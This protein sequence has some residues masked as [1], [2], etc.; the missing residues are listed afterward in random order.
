MI[1]IRTAKAETVKRTVG[2]S[3]AVPL[4]A[5]SLALIGVLNPSVDPAGAATKPVSKSSSVAAPKVGRVCKTPGQVA[6]TAPNQLVCQR[7]TNNKLLW[8]RSRL[9]TNTILSTP[10]MQPDSLQVNFRSSPSA[11]GAVA[12]LA[13]LNTQGAEG[14]AY[15]GPVFV[16]GAN[17]ETFLK[18][19]PTTTYRYET[20]DMPTSV[21]GVMS[22]LRA[23]GKAGLIYKGPVLFADA[24]EK[25]S[26]LFLRATPR[27]PRTATATAHGPQMNR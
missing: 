15:I 27:R 18:A 6:G 9:T 5:L 23:K 10:T 14:Y 26:L 7:G 24:L 1:R 19:E 16:G 8:A 2:F 11:K 21:D 13:L 25:T 12:A 22:L 3:T 4:L 17:H 20:V